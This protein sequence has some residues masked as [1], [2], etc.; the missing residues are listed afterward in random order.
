MREG[1]GDEKLLGVIFKRKQPQDRRVMSSA[2]YPQPFRRLSHDNQEGS[3]EVSC[4]AAL[5]F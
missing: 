2:R 5:R 4:L 3:F 1:R